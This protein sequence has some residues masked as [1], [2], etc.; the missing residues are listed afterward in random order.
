MTRT[1]CLLTALAALAGVPDAR[2]QDPTA[3]IRGRVV[4]SATQQP[5][6]RA[7]VQIGSKGALTQADGRYVITG[8][9]AGRDTIR[10][11]MIGFMP[12]N[13][14]VSV[15]AG[16]TVDADFAMSAQ[17]VNLSEIIVTGYGTQRQGDITGAV[18]QLTTAEFNPGR[19]VSPAQLIAN[20]A[21]G[22]QVVDNNEPGGGL[23]IRIR[24][25]TSVNASNEPLYVIDGL[26]IGAGAGGGLSV[27]GRDPLNALNPNE[28]ES[29]TVLRDAS[30]A[31]IYG[32]NAANGVVLITTKKGARGS[33]I[34]YNGS[35]ST[36]S[37]TRRPNMLNA[38]Q[39]R[40]A[41]QEYA[42]QHASRLQNSSTNWYSLIEESAFGQD[43][44]VAVSNVGESSNWRLSLGYLNQNGIITGTELERLSLGFNL[45]QRLFQDK[46]HVRGNVKGSRTD[47]E[48]TP[49]GVLSNAAQMSPTQPIFD[50][51][52]PTGYFEWTQ[53][54]LTSPDNP[55]AI[56]A[57]T[58]DEAVTYRS[59]GNVRADYQLPFL[60]NLKANLDVGYD[61]SVAE[62]E[63]FVPRLLQQ[64]QIDGGGS[65]FR[66][67]PT[68]I[69]G[70]L[71]SY[72]TYA[73]PLGRS[74][75]TI[76]LA[77][78]YSYG[79]SYGEYPEYRAT[80]LTTD[81]LG[82]NGV[83]TAG[84]VQ[85]TKNIQESK[86]VSVFARLNYNLNDKYLAS[87]SVRRDGSSRFGEG[88]E[89]GT[90][91][92]VSLGWRLS[93][94]SFLANSLFSDLKLRASWALTGNQAFANYQQ[95][96]TY[97]VGDA[98][99]QVQ[100]GNE[101]VSTIRPSAVDPG[102]KWEE[103][104]AYNIGLD[105]GILNQRISG[106]IDWYTKNTDN[107]I[108]T[109]PV[110]AGTNLSNFLTTNIGSMK[111]RGLEFSISARILG[112]AGDG[113]AWTADLIG[114]HNTNELTSINPIFGENIASQRI[115]VGGVAGGVGTLIQ[116]L[117]P[118]VPINSFFVY[119]HKRGPDGKPIY[120][121]ENGDGSINERDLYVD[122]NGDGNVNVDD[123]RP[124]HDPAPKW[125]IGH[126]SYL[127]YKKFDLGL[128]VRAYTGNY[129]YNNVASNLGTYAEL[130]RGSPYNLH[131]SV[132]E[133]GFLQP[134]Y[135]SDYYVEKASFLRMDNLTLGY[136]F[137]YRNL[138]VRVFG[139]LQNAFT[140]TGYDGVDPTAGINGIDNNIYPRSRTF[141]AGLGMRF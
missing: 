62:R 137:E 99:S 42:P 58:R 37:I 131:A 83:V 87:L 6:P 57:F 12:S 19:T 35:L 93:Q 77:G 105:F 76:D 51:S 114:S 44:N 60:Q 108:F 117:Q 122:Q 70:V 23:S 107:L 72:L 118:G 84:S 14:V 79:R 69:D 119:E 112:S 75:G 31:A 7:V 40:A 82:G 140:L 56:L 136:S 88:N 141:T 1:L 86:L 13:R 21:P 124:F 4:D 109:V 20:K 24:G 18:S 129:V 126:S 66:S 59:F 48:F 103:T 50:E 81:V 5:L 47:D 68:R 85:N 65:D 22:V 36:S 33:Y 135:L 91:P 28:I 98:Q 102:I 116:V 110:A 80:D 27:S 11:R 100:F 115:L 15:T 113:L 32:S 46:L 52:S 16:Q 92:S 67:S 128:T 130:G 127:S 26:P 2:A 61:L 17:A 49:G 139:T 25:P 97:L 30:A 133:T 104:N 43:H 10:V 41:V 8:V 39:F 54:K 64:S 134:Q 132:L 53:N 123:R 95:Y 121:D 45:E 78:G 138:P 89:W 74:L 90:F 106:T 55:L 101:Y 73:A 29:I 34:E 125:I 96:S 9:P 71:E 111:N 38:Q 63:T 94:E 120:A 3:T